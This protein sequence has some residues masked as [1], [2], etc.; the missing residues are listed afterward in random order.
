MSTKDNKELVR[1]DF[2]EWNE[3]AGDMAKIHPLFEKYYAPVYIYHHPSRGDINREE[4]IQHMVTLMSALADPNFSIDD[5][6]AEGDKVVIRFTI[7]ASHKGMFMGIPATGKHI[8]VKG[9]QIY[10]IEGRKF[11]EMWELVDALGVM[12]QLGVIPSAALNT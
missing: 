4:R 8:V 3:I 10:K 7:Q 6:V 9:V 2:K 12:T 1:Q 11:V 5:M